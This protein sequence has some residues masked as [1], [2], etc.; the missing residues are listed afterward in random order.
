[1]IGRIIALF[2]ALTAA[3]LEQVRPT[4]LER[5]APCAGIGRALRT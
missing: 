5:F 3:D 2:E 1:M 4:D